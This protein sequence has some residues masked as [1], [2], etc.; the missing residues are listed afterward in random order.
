VRSQTTT[1]GAVAQPGTVIVT[2][3][4]LVTLVPLGEP[5]L[6]EVSIENQDIG[7]VAPKQRYVNHSLV[8]RDY[9][10]IRADALSK[11]PRSTPARASR[12]ASR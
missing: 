1:I 12:S 6:A 2:L 10:S 5:L 11:C 8:D 9:R 7:F 4:T 3:V